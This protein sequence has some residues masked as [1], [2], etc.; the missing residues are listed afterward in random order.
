MAS[1]ALKIWQEPFE[2]VRKGDKR[3]EF[4]FNDRGFQY[5]DTL[6]L[7]E[8]YPAMQ[9]FTGREILVRITDITTGHGIPDGYAMLSFR[10]V[11]VQA[12]IDEPIPVIETPKVEVREGEVIRTCDQG[13]RHVTHKIGWRKCYVRV[14]QLFQHRGAMTTGQVGDMFEGSLAATVRKTPSELLHFD[15]LELAGKR[16]PHA[17][18]RITTLGNAFLSDRFAVPEFVW[19]KGVELPKECVPGPARY[20]RALAR[21]STEGD[22]ASGIGDNGP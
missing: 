17:L 3:A 7:K 22:S 21:T 10:P 1:H 15:L 14:L 20:L 16:G 2:A 8:W 9:G 12:S 6:L 18:Y 4:R 5:G 11:E 13:H 19:P